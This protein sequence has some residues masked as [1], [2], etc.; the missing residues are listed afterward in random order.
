[1]LGDSSKPLRRR[2]PHPPALL[3]RGRGLSVRWLL[4]VTTP[5][6]LGTCIYLTWR[7]PTLRLFDWAETLGTG[8]LLLR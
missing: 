2:D 3:W 8:E 7:S 1:M 5:L 6:L 4:H